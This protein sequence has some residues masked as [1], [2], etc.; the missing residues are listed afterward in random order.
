MLIDEKTPDWAILG[1]SGAPIA[2]AD[3]V[4]HHLARLMENDRKAT[5][6][7]TIFSAPEAGIHRIGEVW[8]GWA[9]NVKRLCDKIDEKIG[10]YAPVARSL[11]VPFVIVV[12]LNLGAGVDEIEMKECTEGDASVFNDRPE[13]SGVLFFPKGTPPLVY[14]ANPNAAHPYKLPI[15][16]G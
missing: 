9:D 13:L 11:D 5:N 12:V 15:S 14:R 7:R 8:V 4:T 16:H 1:A 2:I 3:V 10:K 6:A